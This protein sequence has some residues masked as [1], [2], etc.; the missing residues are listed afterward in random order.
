MQRS[1]TDEGKRASEGRCH[2][3]KHEGRESE[4]FVPHDVRNLAWRERSQVACV[5]LVADCRQWLRLSIAS[6]RRI[7]I[8]VSTTSQPKS[9]RMHSRSYQERRELPQLGEARDVL[10]RLCWRVKEPLALRSSHTH[11]Q[12][13]LIG[14]VGSSVTLYLEHKERQVVQ[15]SAGTRRELL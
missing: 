4:A 2:H 1:G 5:E 14:S 15:L 9:L 7:V 12:S 6:S 3:P 8:C 10:V 11:S 13:D